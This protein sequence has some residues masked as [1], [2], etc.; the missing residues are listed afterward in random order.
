MPCFFNG[1]G[2]GT[3]A[4]RPRAGL[5]PHPRPAQAA[6]PTWS[7]CSAPRSTSASASAASATAPVAH[8]V[9]ADVAAGRA[10]STSRRSPATSAPILRA[11]AD[12]GGDRVDHEPWIA[13]LRDAETAAARAP[14]RRCCAAD[15]DPIKPT[16]HLRRAEQAAGA[17]RGRDLRRRRLRL[18]RRQVTSRSTQPGCWLDT[19]PYGCLGNG[20]G[21]AIAARV[22]RPS[23][24]IVALL[25]DGAAGFSLM[26]ADTLVRHDLPVV[27]IV[28]NNGMWG[29][30]K[31]PMQ[32][33]Y[34]WDV[35]CDLQPGCRYD[36]VVRALGG[37][38]ETVTEPE[39]IGPGARPGLRR[40]RALPGQRADRPGRRLPAVLQPGL[41]A[42]PRRRS[43]ARP[44][45]LGLQLA[46][47]LVEHLPALDPRRQQAVQQLLQL[48]PLGQQLP[49]R[50]EGGAARSRATAA[51]SPSTGAAPRSRVPSS[52]PSAGV[53]EQVFAFV[54][55]EGGLRL[56]CVS[57]PRPTAGRPAPRPH[58][59]SGRSGR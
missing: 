23:S 56:R 53:Y 38:G 26:D 7:S 28:G 25:G 44:S 30:E 46:R 1:L 51:P 52:P 36:E 37:A 42:A 47:Q 4:G 29:L 55:Q 12:H 57:R 9:D 43:P 24:Q 39:E 54:N 2:R 22:A 49:V 20:P 35:A 33:I 21:Y 59:R 32:A 16:P 13:E 58:R 40:R 14:T 19:G 18:V 3:P 17:R 10:T 41:S 11:L 31:H 8:V 45:W 6:R 5:P 27:M 50:L 48:V 15:A 34:G